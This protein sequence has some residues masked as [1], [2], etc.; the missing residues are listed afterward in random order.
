MSEELKL[1]LEMWKL[2]GLR[3]VHELSNIDDCAEVSDSQD[4]IINGLG[5]EAMAEAFNANQDD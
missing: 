1:R 5:I 3:I 2:E 4:M